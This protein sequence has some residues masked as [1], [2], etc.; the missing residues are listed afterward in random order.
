VYRYPARR[1]S[2][3]FLVITLNKRKRNKESLGLSAYCYQAYLSFARKIQ[4]NGR[5]IPRPKCE[6]IGFIFLLPVPRMPVTATSEKEARD[7]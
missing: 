1:I 6:K 3:T 2:S 4:R 7:R 5:G